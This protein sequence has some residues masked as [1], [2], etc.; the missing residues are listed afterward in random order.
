MIKAARLADSVIIE[1]AQEYPMKLSF[2]VM[3]KVSLVFVLA[4][5]VLEE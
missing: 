1:F 4:P 3:D 5:R 2:K